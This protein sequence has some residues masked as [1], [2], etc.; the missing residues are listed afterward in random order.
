MMEG[1]VDA[2]DFVLAE[3]LG[4]QLSEIRALPALEVEEWKAFYEY[5]SAIREKEAKRGT[6]R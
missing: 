2:F 1:T 6:Q 4:A 5:R 3:A